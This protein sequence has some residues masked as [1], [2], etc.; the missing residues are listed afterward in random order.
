[1]DF[2]RILEQM[3]QFFEREKIRY[4][5]VGALGLHAYGLSRATGD[6]DFLAE[7]HA[8]ESIVAFLESLG[9]DTLH[10]S[11]GFSNH[12]H[13]LAA[14][15]RLDFIYVGTLTAD[16]IFKRITKTLNFQGMAIPVPRPEHL[17]AMKIFAMKNDPLREYQEMADLQFLLTLP[18]IDVDEVKG[19][20]EKHGLMEKYDAIRNKLTTP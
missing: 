4:A 12:V 10:A 13:G 15:G 17:A 2:G 5:I 6:M 11:D 3:V 20:F 16:M 18:E 8:R 1:M 14:M 9:Y 19:Y 7:K